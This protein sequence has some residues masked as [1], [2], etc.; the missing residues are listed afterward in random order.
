MHP[1]GHKAGEDSENDRSTESPVLV[2]G[3]T[4][5]STQMTLVDPPMP[6]RSLR[7]GTGRWRGA[8]RK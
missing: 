6:S 4:P 7:L 1:Q 5:G 8:S 2:V 3:G